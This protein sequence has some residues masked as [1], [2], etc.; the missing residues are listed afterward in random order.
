MSY[1]VSNDGNVI[2]FYITT[3]WRGV[4]NLESFSNR[5]T[6]ISDAELDELI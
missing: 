3:L 5:Y 4:Q 2:G 1:L 6:T